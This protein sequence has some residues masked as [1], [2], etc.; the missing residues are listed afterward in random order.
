MARRKTINELD[1]SGQ[2]RKNPGAYADRAQ[3]GA[4][5]ALG[6]PPAHLRDDQRR[7]WVELAAA[8]PDRSLGAGDAFMLEIAA[9]LLAEFRADPGGFLPSKIAQLRSTLVSLGLSPV[10][11]ARV[12]SLPEPPK[13]NVWAQ[14]ANN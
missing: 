8:A 3:E 14:F 11:R 9:T 1:L 10:D 12:S 4:A 6:D 5:R 13:E 7:I 2:L